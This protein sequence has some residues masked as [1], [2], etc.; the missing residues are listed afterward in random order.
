VAAHVSDVELLKKK[1]RK[2][3]AGQV[4]AGGMADLGLDLARMEG[5][6][7]CVVAGYGAVTDKPVPAPWDRLLWIL[8]GRGE[9][10]DFAGTVTYVSQGQSIVLAAGVAYGLVFPQLTIYL[11]V[12]GAWRG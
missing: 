4:L 2:M 3:A 7:V 12:E 10:H 11:R 5:C 1:V 8:D 6:R 9:V